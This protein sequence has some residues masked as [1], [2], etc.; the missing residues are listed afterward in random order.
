[1]K[2]W[3][4]DLNKLLTGYVIIGMSGLVVYLAYIFPQWTLMVLGVLFVNMMAFIIGNYLIK[5]VLDE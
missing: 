3:K 4:S 5:D 1:M 2:N